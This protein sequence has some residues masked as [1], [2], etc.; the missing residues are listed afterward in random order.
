MSVG[1]DEKTAD[2]DETLEKV[3]LGFNHFYLAKRDYDRANVENTFSENHFVGSKDEFFRVE[4]YGF[5]DKTDQNYY[6][7]AE[8]HPT[9]HVVGEILRRL[10]FCKQ[11]LDFVF[12]HPNH[13]GESAKNYGKKNGA[14]I[15]ASGKLAFCHH[16]LDF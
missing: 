9:R 4:S 6:A 15:N 11:A 1:N 5:D 14:Q 12:E 7:N 8:K 16:S 13:G 2:T 3:L 10:G